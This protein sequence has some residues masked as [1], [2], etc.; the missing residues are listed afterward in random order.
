MAKLASAMLTTSPRDASNLAIYLPNARALSL[1][2]RI[3]PPPP[4]SLSNRPCVLLWGGEYSAPPEPAP[5]ANPSPNRLLKQLGI[6]A[7]AENAED[8]LV[9]WRKPLIGPQRRS[10]WHLLRGESVE[11]ACRRVAVKGML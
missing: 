8:I 5:P 7:S 6:A 4:D 1:S 3:E 10:V 11:A 2:A 9:D